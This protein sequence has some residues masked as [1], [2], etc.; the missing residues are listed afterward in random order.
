[1][2]DLAEEFVP[3]WASPPGATLRDALAERGIANGDFANHIGVSMSELRQLFTGELAVTPD[4]ARRLASAI[5][6]SEAFWHVRETQYQHDLSVVQADEWASSMPVQQMASFGWIRRPSG[7]RE[8][9]RICL[10]FFDVPDVATWEMR[11]RDLLQTATFR[12]SNAFDFDTPAVLAWLRESERIALA[13]SHSQWNRALFL[14]NLDT[15]RKLTRTHDPEVFLAR[16][17][18]L[19]QEAGVALV[20]LRAPSGCPVS[21]TARFVHDLPIIVL[22][23][24]H[25]SDDHFWFTF[26]HEAAHLVLHDPRVPYVDSDADEAQPENEIEREANNFAASI[27]I[28]PDVS[29]RLTRRTTTR[30][31]IRLASQL[32]VSP[33]I[34]VGQMQHRGVVP[35]SFHNKLK[36]RFRWEGP[37]LEKA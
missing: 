18:D 32:G 30:D 33:G 9:L 1:M 11:Y 34:V 7:W 20:V 2:S 26:F 29:A 6:P 19:C 35:P 4:L 36:R 5:G 10:Q 24:R 16:L 15:A 23:V 31:I 13:T 22:S 14:A 12:R 21:G 37:T 28:P 8:R 17:T 25:L 3:R 27:L